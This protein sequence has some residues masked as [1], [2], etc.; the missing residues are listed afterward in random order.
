MGAF[1]LLQCRCVWSLHVL[2]ESAWVQSGYDGWSLQA[3][4]S[5]TNQQIMLKLHVK[6]LLVI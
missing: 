2:C 6:E 4:T 3:K 5:C 1:V